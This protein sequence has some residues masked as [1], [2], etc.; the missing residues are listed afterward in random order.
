MRYQRIV[1]DMFPCSLHVFIGEFDHDQFMK[2]FRQIQKKANLPPDRVP[3]TTDLGFGCCW[4]MGTIQIVWLTNEPQRASDFSEMVHELTH[5]ALHTAR[6]LGFYQHRD[7][8]D[9][10][11]CYYIQWATFKILQKS[12]KKN[13]DSKADK[14]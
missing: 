8:S 11:T 1:S 3:D 5:A 14:D 2:K 4:D 10:F 6:H 7:D 13:V 9:E 12:W